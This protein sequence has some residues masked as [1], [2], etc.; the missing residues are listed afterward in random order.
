MAPS[1]ASASVCIVRCQ[2][3]QSRFSISSATGAPVVRPRRTPDCTT[4]RIGLDGH[5][6]AAAVAALAPPEGVGEPV[7]IDGKTGGQAIDDDHETAAM[8]LAGGE[9]PQHRA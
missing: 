8:R 5:A 6:P 3:T 1:G 9:K 2:F 7:E 4:A